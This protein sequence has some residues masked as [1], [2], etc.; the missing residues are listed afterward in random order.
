MSSIATQTT[1]FLPKVIPVLQKKVIG[2]KFMSTMKRIH[3]SSVKSAEDWTKQRVKSK[4]IFTSVI[5]EM[6]QAIRKRKTAQRKVD[7]DTLKARREAKREQKAEDEA[8]SLNRAFTS[9]VKKTAERE[10]AE[11]LASAKVEAETANN[12]KIFTK[13][14]K[15]MTLLIRKRRTAVRKADAEVHKAEQEVK[16]AKRFATKLVKEKAR[17]EKKMAKFAKQFAKKY[18]AVT[19]TDV[20]Y[21]AYVMAGQVC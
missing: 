11:A 18:V 13:I 21:D 2:K 4:K 12:K 20:E 15:E 6:T 8:L 14:V 3:K 19:I 16:R 5:N 17:I 9:M 7:A 1:T 10:R